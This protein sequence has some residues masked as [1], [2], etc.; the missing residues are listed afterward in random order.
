[1]IGWL[2]PSDFKI[3][4]VLEELLNKF[5]EEVTLEEEVVLLNEIT[6]VGLTLVSLLTT[7]LILLNELGDNSE[8]PYYIFTI[9]SIF[10]I[11]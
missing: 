6:G 11:G 2:I 9:G 7:L 5:I 3:L 1:V 4:G 8:E 10:R